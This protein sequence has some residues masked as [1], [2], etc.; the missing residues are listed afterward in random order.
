MLGPD[1]PKDS[2]LLDPHSFWNI[3]QF[4]LPLSSFLNILFSGLNASLGEFLKDEG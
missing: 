2:D 4:I 1:L 3:H